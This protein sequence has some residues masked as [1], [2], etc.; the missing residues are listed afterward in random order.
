MTARAFVIWITLLLPGRLFAQNV[1]E[2]QV[3]PPSVTIKVGERAALLATAFDRAGNVIPTV[4]F[5]WSSNNLAV[6]KIDNEGT[7]TAV[8]GGVALIEARVGAR[9]GQAA[10]QVIASQLPPVSGAP[11]PASQQP[12]AEPVAPAADGLAGQ[13]PGTGPA[14]VLRIE[15]PTVYLLPSENTRVYPRPLKEDGSPAAPVSVTW[16]S[17]RPD[18]ASVDQNGLVVALAPGQGT[19]QVISATGLTATAPVV[20]QQSDIAIFEATP[21]ALSPGDV[22][23]LHVIVPAQGN[24]VVSPVA[25]QWATADPNIAR[26]SLTGVVT[27]VAPGRTTLLVSGLLQSKVIDVVVHKSGPS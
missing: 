15:P 1:S 25:M 10:V 14:S 27:A 6:A 24:R 13:P 8:G 11:P 26:V 2:V 22:D 9:R 16:R 21:V 3:A 17:L 20:V 19:V 12:P 4:T 7:V 5:I 18:I 23:T